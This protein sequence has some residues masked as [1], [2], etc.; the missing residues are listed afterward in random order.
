[1]S[2]YGI[3]YYGL[4]YYGSANPVQYDANPFT[5]I[6]YGYGKILLNWTDPSGSWSQLIVV[7]NAYGYPIDPWDGT[8]ILTVNN[9]LDPVTFVDNYQI[10]TGRFYYY[11]IFVFSTISYTWFTAATAASLAV[12]NYGNTDKLYNYLPEIYKMTTPYVA[13]ADMDNQAL[14]GFLANF[15]F[16]LDTVQTYTDLLTHRYNVEL[17][18]AD[19]LPT[20]MNQ[21]GLTF[22]PSLGLQQ[23]RILLRDAVALAQQKGTL[24]GLVG[25]IKDFSGCTVPQPIPNPTFTLTN[26]GQ[27]TVTASSQSAAPNPSVAGI[28]I[29]HNLMLSALDSSFE[30]IGGR[31][32]TGHWNSADGTADFDFLTSFNVKTAQ[33]TSNV[34]TLTLTESPLT[35]SITSAVLYANVATFTTSFTHNM[36]VGDNVTI[37]NLSSPYNGNQ[38]ITAVTSN[39]FSVP[40]T[41]TNV[42]I[43]T[44]LSGTV[45]DYVHMWDVGNFITVSGLPSPLFNSATPVQITAVTANSISYALTGTNTGVLSGYNNASFAYGIVTPY[46]TPWV[47][48][49]A[50]T[51][52]P[53]LAAGIMAVYNTSTTAQNIDAYCGDSNPVTMG[54]PVTAGTTYTF[55]FYAAKDYGGTARNVQASIKW[56]NRLG[57]YISTSTGTAVSDNTAVF[58]SGYRPYISAVAPANAYY[59]TS[60]VIVQ[61]IG[62]SATKEHHYVD[63]CQFEAASSP[64]SFDEARQLH[65]TLRANRINELINPSFNSPTTPWTATGATVG[66]NTTI[67]EPS[68]SYSTVYNVTAT[69]ISSNVATVTVSQAHTLRVGNVVYLTGISGTGVTAS[70]YNGARTITAVTTTTFSYAV[71]ATNQALTTTT[72]TAYYQAQALS[73][74]AT[75]TSVSLKSWDGATNSQQMGIYYPGTD[76]A[77]SV[78]VRPL[79]ANET[80][81]VKINWYNTSHTLISTSSGNPTVVTANVWNQPSVI[82]IAPTTAAYATVELDYTTT[83]GNVV[84]VDQALFE[85]AGSVL[86]YFDGF[87]GNGA[88]SDFFWEGGVTN[89]ARSHYYK[90]RFAIQTRLYGATLTSQ[91]NLGS[92]A[93][94]YLAQPQT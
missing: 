30:K 20:M 24:E 15:G 42:P 51:L 61:S 71:T 38:T 93:A 25:F 7:R 56:Y 88:T 3:D 90:N 68:G 8:T 66:T 53:N 23:N 39:T 62:G 86:S 77:F 16:Q 94:I 67:P 85:N 18:S 69:Q 65:I 37:S 32:N 50:P 13:T 73:L 40:I 84:L 55:S 48:P 54:I 63:A 35:Y 26:N 17:I 28:V 5:A 44:G 64:T 83:V 36:L 75:G 12:T 70:N 52:F 92:T 19:L 81:T 59:A 31:Q 47:E 41:Y 21:F 46:P 22:E 79:T 87:G 10:N 33:L 45:Q 49:T 76:Y 1:M 72:G 91:L 89:A 29:G 78:Y 80:V 2:R 43:A 4:A 34:A 6:P 58:A 14:Y 74:T 57:V 11:S 9:G 60:G 27:Y 82:D